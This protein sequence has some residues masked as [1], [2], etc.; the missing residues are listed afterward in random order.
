MAALLIGVEHSHV[1]LHDRDGVLYS[2]A[3]VEVEACVVT[4]RGG[5]E[6]LI[7]Q[8]ARRR[9]ER[10]GRSTAILGLRFVDINHASRHLDRAD[11]SRQWAQ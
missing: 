11:A 4:C 2:G 7:P 1:H 3:F 10:R 6:G 9:P 8:V 5:S